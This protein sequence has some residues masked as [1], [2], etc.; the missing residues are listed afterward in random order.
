MPTRLVKKPILVVRD[1]KQVSPEVGKPYD[2]TASEVDEINKL[3][4]SAIEIIETPEAPVAP[5]SKK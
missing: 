1:G 5:A 2:L 4:P 3:N